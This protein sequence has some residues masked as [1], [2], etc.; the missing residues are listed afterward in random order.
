MR[1]LLATL[2]LSIAA[3]PA[4]AAGAYASR[5]AA[6]AAACARLCAEDGLCMLWSYTPQNQCELRATAPAAPPAGV[7]GFS[8]RAPQALRQSFVN[9]SPTPASAAPLASVATPETPALPE[10]TARTQ[11]EADSDLLGGP[12]P[13]SAALRPRL[14]LRN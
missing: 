5:A 6:D 2:L 3:A 10:T 8:T 9:P 12:E 7:V 11:E 14:D 13:Q 4:H 1:I